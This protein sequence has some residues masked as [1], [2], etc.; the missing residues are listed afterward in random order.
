M[1]YNN[2][3]GVKI[4]TDSDQDKLRR[5]SHNYVALKNNTEYKLQLINDRS[6][7]C[8]AEVYIEG[9][10]VGTWFINAKGSITI[11]RPANTPRKFTFFK[12][13]DSRA[14]NAG[15]I[16]G[17]SF[18]GV[19]RVVF[20]PKKQYMAIGSPRS[21]YSSFQTRPGNSSSSALSVSP[22]RSGS[23]SPRRS[24]LPMSPSRSYQ[25]SRP[26]SVMSPS[27]SV[28]MSPSRSAPMSPSRSVPMS[29]S[30]SVTTSP[31][32][33][34][35]A[36][37]PVSVMS[38][39]RSVPMSPSRS[40]QASRPVSV[41]SPSRSYQAS[42]PVSVMSPSRSVAMSP[43]RSVPMNPSR[44]VAM[45]PSRSYQSG[46]TVLGGESSQTFG[47]VRRFSDNEIDWDNKTEITL[48]LIVKPE[49]NLLISTAESFSG[50]SWERQFVAIKNNSSSIPPR[51]DDYIPII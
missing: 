8:M 38:P 26:V 6:T 25:A 23:M 37:R 32:R 28:P 22:S 35:Q 41:M 21:S 29:P 30:R 49:D 50:N 7:D 9:D 18:N 2:G 1:V 17:Q 15:V 42:R 20:Y 40:Y 16:V 39:S 47:S 51:I 45:S 4:I 43:S 31:S 27:R 19:L 33:S 34:Y 48:R 24:V 12:E 36:S 13:N 44:S 10:L 46:A 14:K 3:F 5:N 11:N